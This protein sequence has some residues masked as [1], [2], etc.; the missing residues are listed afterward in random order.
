[1][2]KDGRNFCGCPFVVE[3]SEA[4]RKAISLC[5]RKKFIFFNAKSVVTHF[6]FRPFRSLKKWKILY[7]RISS[8]FICSIQGKREIRL[9]D[10]IVKREKIVGILDLDKLESDKTKFFHNFVK[11]REK[12][13]TF[14]ASLLTGNSTRF[15]FS[16]I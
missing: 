14:K 15:G 12:L 1:M 4:T 2:T 8:T 5:E 16:L 10:L 6:V 3:D 11:H 13:L 7:N 9:E